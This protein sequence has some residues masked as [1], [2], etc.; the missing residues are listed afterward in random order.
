[1]GDRGIEKEDEEEDLGEDQQVSESRITRTVSSSNIGL[2][3]QQANEFMPLNRDRSKS[4]VGSRPRISAFTEE[5]EE[6]DI[7]FKKQPQE[8][9]NAEEKDSKTIKKGSR[10]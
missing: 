5:E 8:E 6:D 3:Q 2:Q 1:M 4:A 7:Q 10:R 9:V